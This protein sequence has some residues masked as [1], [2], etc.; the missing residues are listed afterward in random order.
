[1][2]VSPAEEIAKLRKIIEFHNHRY[3]DLDDPVLS[4]T[5][6]DELYQK[7][8][9]LE[10]RFPQF[11]TP[12]SP[13]QKIGGKANAT[14]AP[15]VHGVP[16][17]SLD[18]S[19]NTADVRA[20]HERCA[21]TLS[22]HHFE[23]VVE[24]K[25]DGVS[26]SLTY[27]NGI[28]TTA[29]SRGDGHTG[30]DITANV[31]TIAD[32]PHR[33]INA[34]AGILEVRGEIYLEKKDL[35][36]LNERQAA[37]K[38]TIFANTRNAAAGSLRQKDSRITA[39][40][41]LKFFVHSFGKSMLSV[42]SFSQFMDLCQKWGF[43]VSPSRLVTYS[44]E[45]ILSFYQHFD[46]QR[47]SL[48]FD[49]DGLVIKV[50]NFNQQQILGS[51]A[52]SPRWAIAFKYPA[53]QATTLV[54][55][56]IFSV[57][58]SGIITP[59][60]Q[61]EPVSCAGVVISNATL[62][63]FDEINRLGLRIGDK[64]ILERAGEVIPKII[65]VV[66]HLG[67]QEILPPTQCPACGRSVYK[68]EKEVGYYCINPSCPAQIKA[69][70][71]HYASRG[72]M[73]IEGMGEAVVEEL[74]D[75]EFVTNFPDLYNLSFLHLLSLENFKEKKSQNLLDQLEESKK[76]PL[77]RLL[78]GF[79]IPFV[80]SKT[81]EMLADHFHTLDHLMNASLEDLQAIADVGEVVSQSVY[82]FFHDPSVKEQIEQLR[83]I[84]INFIQPEK[85]ISSRILEGKTIVFTGEIEGVKR[86]EAELL[87]R[88]HGAKTSGSVS[89][90]TSFVVAAESAGSKLKK[91]QELGV[92]ILTPEEFFKMIA[93]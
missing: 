19:Y 49:T 33:L 74:V 24:A 54:K 28:L 53:E 11:I 66:E 40:R 16:M 18:N 32:I 46:Q 36:N 79:G 9:E 48:P 47:H 70:I 37:N 86:S 17:M 22:T 14:F 50:N 30:E 92:P 75:R 6:Y 78:F 61:V 39:Q 72:A 82:D 67:N 63:N 71:L 64:I 89:A 3:Y 2:P 73:D 76:R 84:G 34:P 60:A 41:P 35:A 31:L 85:K 87:A 59:V 55:N 45:D 20:W 42:D 57:G 68:A 62:H 7:L 93:S 21:K 27:T 29:A 80:G 88:Q 77:S 91:A 8:K 69:R 90:K 15:V 43:A 56:V 81:A 1:M 13:T 4:D 10:S 65:K 52:K 5:Q 38:Q 12:D 25:I 83:Q 44:L 26:C 51:T 58:R 23:M